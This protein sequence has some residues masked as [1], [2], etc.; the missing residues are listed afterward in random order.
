MEDQTI[1]ETE[2]A[3]F[4]CELSKPNKKV[5][6]MKNKKTLKASQR[7]TMSTDKC[8]Q[9]LTIKDAVMDDQEEY[10]C[11]L[12]NGNEVSAKLTVIGKLKEL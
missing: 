10:T 1:K 12:P 2:T 8:I 4:T 6:W 3:E 11:V 7:I 5:Q 9:K